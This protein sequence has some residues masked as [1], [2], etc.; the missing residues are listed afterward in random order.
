MIPAEFHAPKCDDGELVL[1]AERAVFKKPKT[2]EVVIH[3]GSF[4][5]E[6]DRAH[7]G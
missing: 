6:T 4:G 2:H 5:R 7:D 1:S 3:Q